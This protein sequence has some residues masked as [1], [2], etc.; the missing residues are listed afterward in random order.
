MQVNGLR[1][2]EKCLEM[3]IWWQITTTGNICLPSILCPPPPD[4]R[5]GHSRTRFYISWEILRTWVAQYVLKNFFQRKLFLTT[6]PPPSPKKFRSVY[7]FRGPKIFG[8]E[9]RLVKKYKTQSL[10]I[11][12]DHVHCAPAARYN[13]PHLH[14]YFMLFC[15]PGSHFTHPHLFHLSF[16]HP[17][18]R[19][20]VPN[21]A[22]WPPPLPES[23]TLKLKS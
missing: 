5:V 16:S 6:S 2:F 8:W 10:Q 1:I 13:C 23:Q 14:F 7:N 3:P 22:V 21:S 12:R 19:R 17:R 9:K 18:S 15:A 11:L 20:K 4:C